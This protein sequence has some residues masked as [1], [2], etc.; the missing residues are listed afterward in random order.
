MQKSTEGDDFFNYVSS[1]ENH[2]SFYDKIYCSCACRVISYDF[3][4]NTYLSSTWPK[5][6]IVDAAL[7]V[8]EIIFGVVRSLFLVSEDTVKDWGQSGKS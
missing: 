6:T 1:I 4:L 5:L 3:S 8:Q 2:R 7:L